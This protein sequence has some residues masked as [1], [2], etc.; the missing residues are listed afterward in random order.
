MDIA[1]DFCLRMAIAEMECAAQQSAC[2]VAFNAVSGLFRGDDSYDPAIISPQQVAVA[3]HGSAQGKHRNLFARIQSGA[4]AALF[5]QFKRKH[6][7]TVDFFSV[8]YFCIQCQ[9]DSTG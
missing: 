4:Q 9:H 1:A 8:L 7:F 2:R 3:Q 6:E 5:A